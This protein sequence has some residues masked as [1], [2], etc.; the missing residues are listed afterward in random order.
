MVYFFAANLKKLTTSDEVHAYF[1]RESDPKWRV[2]ETKRP[3]KAPPTAHFRKLTST[4]A[5]TKEL[6]ALHSL[7]ADSSSHSIIGLMYIMVMIRSE[8]VIMGGFTKY[9]KLTKGCD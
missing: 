1:L 2:D 7:R 3:N 9:L 8:A 4:K 6:A 5:Q